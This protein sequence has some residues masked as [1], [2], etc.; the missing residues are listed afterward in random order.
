MTATD[1]MSVL[2]GQ[3]TI[4]QSF[5][6]SASHELRLLPTSHKCHRN[7]G[8]NYTATCSALVRDGVSGDLSPLGDYMA[9]TFEHRLLN[10]QAVR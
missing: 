10:E 1:E 7:H 3:I 6:F 8:H 5:D 2:D 9:A 4:S